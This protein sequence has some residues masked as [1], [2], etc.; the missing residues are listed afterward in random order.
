MIHHQYSVLDFFFLTYNLQKRLNHSV[1]NVVNLLLINLSVFSRD[2]KSVRSLNCCV[3][4]NGWVISGFI[5]ELIS[6]HVVRSKKK[7]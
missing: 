1:V 5:F 6:A 7:I 3:T 4:Q 2:R